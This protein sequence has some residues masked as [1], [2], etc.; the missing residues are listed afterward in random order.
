MS[1]FGG[2]SGG[3]GITP[4]FRQTLAN[5]RPEPVAPVAPQ[6]TIPTGLRARILEHYRRFGIPFPGGQV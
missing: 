4:L 5:S 1:I 6:T 2:P 3:S